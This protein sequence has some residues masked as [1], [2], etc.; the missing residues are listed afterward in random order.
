MPYIPE[1]GWNAAVR[2]CPNRW[3]SSK[4]HRLK[5]FL[6][7]TG[8]TDSWKDGIAVREIRREAE[9]CMRGVNYTWI[10]HTAGL[11]NA[12]RAWLISSRI[13]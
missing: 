10:M 12:G 6:E 9:T 5:G 7:L 2:N 3:R 4:R 1:A 11:P 8:G 13:E